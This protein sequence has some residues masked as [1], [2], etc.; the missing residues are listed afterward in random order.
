[1]L[2]KLLQT[3]QTTNKKNLYAQVVCSVLIPLSYGVTI[4]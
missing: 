3:H 4:L 2:S 1:M